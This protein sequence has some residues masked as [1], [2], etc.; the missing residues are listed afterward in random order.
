MADDRQPT[1]EEIAALPVDARALSETR[2]WLAGTAPTEVYAPTRDPDDV[3]SSPDHRPLAAQPRWRQDFPIDWPADGFVA[4]RDFVRFLV[5]TSLAFVSGQAWIVAKRVLRRRAPV[6]VPPRRKIATL[7]ELPPGTAR[8]FRYPAEEPCLLVR[9]HDGQLFA[10]GQ[11]CTH[12]A[13]AVVPEIAQGR[14]RCPCHEGYFALR[15]G[16]NIAGPPPRPLPSITL[17]LRGEDVFAVGV[18]P[19]TV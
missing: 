7:T 16:Q 6:A 2:E 1:D 8:V 11:S 14:L 19:R 3:T 18:K 5:L 9:D 15:T 13:C 12:L 17:E 10:Y 4:R